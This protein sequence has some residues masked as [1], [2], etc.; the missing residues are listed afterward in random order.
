MSKIIDYV[1][2]KDPSVIK[3]NN[4]HSLCVI[5]GQCMKIVSKP[6]SL[7]FKVIKQ[8]LNDKVWNDTDLLYVV[9]TGKEYHTIPRHHIKNDKFT[10]CIV[11]DS[12]VTKKRGSIIPLMQW[13]ED[14]KTCT[15]IVYVGRGDK[16]ENL[17]Y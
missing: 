1:E 17:E 11:D 15:S 4:P 9:P 10:A 12:L 7:I 14:H 13:I 16:I 3:Y 6:L 8:R 2:K 5:D